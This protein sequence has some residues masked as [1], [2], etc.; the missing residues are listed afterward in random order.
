M[1]Y[2]QILKNR[3]I[4]YTLSFIFGISFILSIFVLRRV[5]F[6]GDGDSFNQTYP[7][8]VYIGKYIRSILRGDFKTF[9]FRIGFGEDIISV[10]NY[11]GFGD[12]LSV[13]A[14]FFPVRFS[15]TA[16]NLV[17][18]LKLYL[19]G[20]AF[21]VYAKRYIKSDHVIVSGA[22]MYSLSAFVLFRG[23]GF[24][25]FINPVFLYPFILSGID[26]ICIENKRISWV[27]ILSVCWQALNGFY[28]LY[29]NAILAI[30]YFVIIILCKTEGI[31]NKLVALFKEGIAVLWQAL[32]GIGAGAVVFIPGII[33]Y[34]NSSRTRR[35]LIFEKIQDYFFFDVD[36]YL[37]N[38]TFPP[39][40]LV[41]MLDSSSKII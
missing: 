33:G 1:N 34:F 35:E 29:I 2:K 24:W 12:L 19:C 39:A 30:I 11:Y 38:S 25:M 16:Y 28:F 4:K 5:S 6:I 22:L 37:N 15:E 36:F 7:V 40:K 3:Y 31:S 27:L 23:M 41:R 14:A 18:L 26:E 20:I 17:M 10:L 13:F 8:F 32:L 9:D 21:L